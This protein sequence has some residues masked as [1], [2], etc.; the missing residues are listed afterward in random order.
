MIKMNLFQ[1]FKRPLVL[2]LSLLTLLIGGLM[3]VR[4][5]AKS[6]ETDGAV[7]VKMARLLPPQP[8][9]ILG[10][11]TFLRDLDM[12]AS[13][14]GAENV[15]YI[16]QVGGSTLAVSVQGSYA[17]IGQGP[18]LAILDISNQASPIVVE[19]TAPLPDIVLARDSG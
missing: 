5:T 18:H 6:L 7:E 1:P 11:T 14:G 19:K 9:G 3:T 4:A 15:E 12:H 17:Y 2:T 10:P 16:G 13:S 8:G